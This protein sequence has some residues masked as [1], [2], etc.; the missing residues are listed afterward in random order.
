MNL[1]KKKKTEKPQREYTRRQISHLQKQRRRQRIIFFGGIAVIAAV[2]IIILVGW[3]VG[4]YVPMHRTV[5]KANDAE[6][7]MSYYIDVL[8]IAVASQGTSQ[9]DM[10]AGS[11]VQQ[12]IQD[13]YIR[14]AAEKLG[15]TV[16]DEEAKQTLKNMDIPENDGSIGL[17]RGELLKNNL[18]SDY[19]GAQVPQS[20]EQAYVMA[21]LVES[22]RVALE[23]TEKLQN[24][25][26]FT[27]LAEE[28]AQNYYSK[29]VNQ[30]DFG[31]H[32]RSIYEYQ[33]GSDVAI[34]YA[35]NG[36]VGSLSDPL[37]DEGAYKQ[38]GY[39]LLRIN[40]RLDEE[41]ANVSALLIS[42]QELAEDIRGRLVAGE[43]LGPIADEYS[44]YSPS[45]EGHGE[46]GLVQL[47]QEI[48]EPFNG[49]VFNTENTTLGEWSDPIFDDDYWTEGGYWLIEVV[50]REEDRKIGAEDR[51][52]LIS[53][54]YNN[55]LQGV[56]A[57]I[58]NIADDTGLDEEARQW[59]ID[60]VLKKLP[61]AEG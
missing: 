6:F 31:W 60:H 51:D 38:L 43:D 18:R 36:E 33:L 23:I 22:E 59:A 3:I 30:G 9:I 10:L 53:E 5:I 32:P 41:T 35:F 24:S 26:N 39:W 58:G 49:Y 52:Y 47:T 2:V 56:T 21:M 50:D 44:N 45:Q 16:S 20:A 40:E 48:S 25:D 46:L 27:T 19:F 54:L 42:S 37:Y 1:A 8:E 61:E 14:Q 11:V 55:W 12:I 57:N 29:N 7:D 13:E 34:E 4:E 15:I 28:F 17:M